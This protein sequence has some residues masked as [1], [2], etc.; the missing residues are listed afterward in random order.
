M[1]HFYPNVQL[2][3]QGYI[4]NA[5]SF[6]DYLDELEIP[7]YSIKRIVVQNDKMH[8]IHLDDVLKSEV[9]LAHDDENNTHIVYMHKP[10]DKW[11]YYIES[12]YIQ[13]KNDTDIEEDI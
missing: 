13:T 9:F 1:I 12:I 11:L 5:L 3:I 6:K 7:F 4:I 2:N 10:E 8:L